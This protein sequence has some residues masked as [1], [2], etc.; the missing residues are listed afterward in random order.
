MK[1]I[2]FKVSKTK[3]KGLTKR[4]NSDVEIIGE[5][6]VETEDY[7]MFIEGEYELK[8]NEKVIKVFKFR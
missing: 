3:K 2:D 5:D 6:Y 1:T 7:D 8:P 4:K